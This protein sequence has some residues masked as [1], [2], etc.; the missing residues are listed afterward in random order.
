M[1][2]QKYSELKLRSTVLNKGLYMSNGLQT[3]HKL[4]RNIINQTVL[5]R[6]LNSVMKFPTV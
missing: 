3:L 5:L 4:K 1:H 6:F 2:H